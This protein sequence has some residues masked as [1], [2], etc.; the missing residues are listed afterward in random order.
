MKKTTALILTAIM[1]LTTIM[2][3]GCGGKKTV[4]VDNSDV[5]YGDIPENL[6]TEKVGNIKS[7]Y[8]STCAGGL[9]YKDDETGLYG[10]MSLE[11][12]YDTG[13]IY[14]TCYDAGGYFVVS[15][16]DPASTY[17]D[18][19]NVNSYGVIDGKGNIIVPY[20]YG[21]I[22]TISERYIVA[23]VATSFLGSESDY[24]FLVHTDCFDFETDSYSVYYDG[25][26]K[27]FDVETGNIVLQGEGNYSILTYG[28]IL[29]YQ[30]VDETWKYCNSNGTVLPE[31][32]KVFDNG[33]YSLEE[34]VGTVYTADGETLF[35]YDLTGF[36]PKS[37]TE[38]GT[39]VASKYLDSGT[40][41]VVMNDK[42]EAISAEFNDYI[43]V[44]GALIKCGNKIYNYE[45]KQVID[46]EFGTTY[47]E[48]MYG[49][50]WL[51]RNDDDVYTMIL[52][53]GSILYRDVYAGDTTIYSDTFVASTKNADGDYIYYSHKDKDYTI[54][55]YHFAPWIIKAF[56]ADSTYD[57]IDT[58][59][60]KTMLSGYND[61]SYTT[62]DG[63]AYY[64][65]AKYND[66]A[67]VYLI[68]NGETV[69]GME[70][71]RTDLL[72]ALTTAFSEEGIEVSVNR[73]TGEIAFDS[74]V[75]FGGDSAELTADGKAFLNKFIK[76]YVSVVGS[77]EYAN[78]VSKT[79]VEGH[80]APV[81]GV[82]YASGLPLSEERAA[83]VKDYCLSSETGVDTS[84][85]ASTLEDI[86]YSNSQP[87]YDASGAPD[88]AA[89][90]R[91][92]FRIMMSLDLLE[93]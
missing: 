27:V 9:Y 12:A 87:V 76:A 26:W 23:G 92:S 48:K 4:E 79:M 7:N 40:V 89:S 65:Y 91:V 25:N 56:A 5:H 2:L 47:H 6:V 54:E 30:D 88:L 77:E 85:I 39:Y 35:N 93:Q 55:G 64:V 84:A 33:T 80:V 67:D 3:V 66:G 82:T 70:E 50:C 45:G 74:S 20:G 58:I 38:Y 90:R 43:D 32:V 19:D 17:S 46:G 83:S 16:G 10:V 28:D 81:D 22:Y 63:T 51:L 14:N 75:L 13:A 44:Y 11:G 36:I 62:T 59:T 18:Y 21:H 69:V 52:E 29:G 31:G 42:G 68:T 41:H 24:G 86:G 61:Y 1:L 60:G 57:L 72:T 49:S 8:F 53:D 71:K 15:V 73:E 34:Q 78:C 37:A